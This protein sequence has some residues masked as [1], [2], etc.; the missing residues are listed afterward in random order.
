MKRTKTYILFLVF[1]LTSLLLPVAVMAAPVV[2]T[3]IGNPFDTFVDHDQPAGSYDSTNHLEMVLTT[4]D[5]YLPD[6]MS[7]QDITPYLSSWEISD[8]R[9][10]LTD[11]HSYRIL[12]IDAQ[13][14][15]QS[16]VSWDFGFWYKDDHSDPGDPGSLGSRM[17][18]N[19]I[20][21]DEDHASLYYWVELGGEP[22]YSF[23]SGEVSSV[24]TW[25]M[26]VDPIPEPA[27]ILL[28]GTGLLGLAGASRRKFKM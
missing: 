19:N 10:T 26:S 3:Y 17:R 18:S 28:L 27:T 8:G 5:G 25:S 6:N 21:G 1:S 11:T 16:I 20:Y 12:R 7:R 15:G 2:Y 9:Y 22:A 13:V 4:I 24:G 14:T 23:D